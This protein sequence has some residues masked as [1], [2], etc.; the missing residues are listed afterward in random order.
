MPFVTS[1]AHDEAVEQQEEPLEAEC[2]DGIG[3]E[4]A[5][6]L[7]ELGLVGDEARARGRFGEVGERPPSDGRIEAQDEEARE[8]AEIACGHPGAAREVAVGRHDAA[9]GPHGR[10]P[11]RRS[12][13]RRPR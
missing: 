7:A 9:A 2:L 3:D 10:A 12:A 13:G 11:L 6:V 1:S 8:N 4:A 5:E